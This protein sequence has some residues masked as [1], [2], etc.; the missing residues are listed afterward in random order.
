VHDMSNPDWLWYRVEQRAANRP[1]GLRPKDDKIFVDRVKEWAKAIEYEAMRS[2]PPMGG[3]W[4]NNPWKVS[5]PLDRR[6]LKA[7]Y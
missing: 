6:K 7:K 3:M 2:P 1:D 4:M 5:N